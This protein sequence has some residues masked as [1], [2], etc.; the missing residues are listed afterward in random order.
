MLAGF[1][2]VK[3]DPAQLMPERYRERKAEPP[4]KSERQIEIE[5]AI[6]WEVLGNFLSSKPK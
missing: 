2:G 6:A 1:S 4:K 5:S 3:A